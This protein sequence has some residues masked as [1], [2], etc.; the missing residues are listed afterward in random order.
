MNSAKWSSH[1]I[2]SIFP[3]VSSRAGHKANFTHLVDHP[4]KSF[5]YISQKIAE[6]SCVHLWKPITLLLKKF[7][8]SQFSVICSFFH[9]MFSY[10]ALPSIQRVQGAVASG[11]S[12]LGSALTGD[13]VLCSWARHFTLTVPL[14]TQVY[15]QVHVPANFMLGGNPV[16]D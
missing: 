13:I 1:F 9:S 4:V 3:E 15:K 2:F 11:A 7:V 8:K 10:I 16:M 14:S 5:S 12:S 6:T